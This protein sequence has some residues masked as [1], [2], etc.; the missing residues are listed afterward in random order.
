MV[1][2]ISIEIEDR[3][4]ALHDAIVVDTAAKLKKAGAFVRRTARKQIKMAGKGRKNKK[5][6]KRAKERTSKP[7]ERPLGH[8]RNDRQS[9]KAIAFDATENEVL[10]GV[11]GLPRKRLAGG[12]TAAE[13]LEHGGSQVLQGIKQPDGSFES[14]SDRVAKRLSIKR[15]T[16]SVR[17][18]ARPFMG[19]ALKMDVKA[20]LVRKIWG[21]KK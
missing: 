11:L 13:I 7:G 15:E 20:G 21:K 4:P 6:K 9:L 18:A 2:E 1:A 12:K 14:V 19:P 3:F 5:T 8:L 17:Y 10:I 16:K